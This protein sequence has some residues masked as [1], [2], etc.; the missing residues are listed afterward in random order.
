MAGHN[1]W[2]KIKHQKAKTDAQKSKTFTKMVR[3]IS[4]EAKKAQGN[5]SSPGL[6]AAIEKAK[7]EN[8]P[9]DTI[10]RAISKATTDTSAAMETVVYESYGPGGS[11]IVIVALTDNRNK[12]AQEVKHILSNHSCELAGIGSA[13]WAFTKT[14]EGYT[15]QTTVPLEDADGE[16]LSAL[17]EELEEN[18]DVQDVCTNAE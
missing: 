4:A 13:L 8:V 9:N 14:H 18:D 11:A 15:A 7:K 3:L 16:K 17:V 2:S 6:A 5:L 12:T 10:D 1:K